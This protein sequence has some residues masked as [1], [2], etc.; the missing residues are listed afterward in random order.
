[1]SQP[2]L[3]LWTDIIG[4]TK[5]A[6]LPP[7]GR[8]VWIIILTLARLSPEPGRLLIAPGEPAG[9]D[10]IT[11]A[12]DL[13]DMSRGCHEDVTTPVTRT[14]HERVTQY[15]ETMSRL[16]LLTRGSDGVIEVANW[17]R[18]QERRPSDE[19][20]Q[21]RARK[22]KSRARAKAGHADVTT[23][24]RVTSQNVTRQEA[25]AEADISITDDDDTRARATDVI[26]NPDAEL[27]TFIRANISILESVPD[28]R[29]QIID[30]AN[31]LG[32]ELTLEACKRAVAA[33]VRKLNY[34][35]SI[36]ETWL[37]AG[38]KTLADVAVLDE[39]HKS[40]QQAAGKQR[41]GKKDR[42]AR[43]GTEPEGGYDDGEYAGMFQR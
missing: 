11:R 1:M 23:A 12:A 41:G 39:Q 19:P 31:R 42:G 3:K 32:P 7:E 30:Y 26:H 25:E 9:I 16:G 5:L 27:W 2:W 33:N 29:D 18:R 10:D 6:R 14:C 43:G 8:W 24:D 20:E 17:E 28:N 40:R 4:D 21:T 35:A 22:A 13:D 15:V 34:V 36:C 38:A 37:D